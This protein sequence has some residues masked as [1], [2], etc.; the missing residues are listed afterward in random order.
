MPDSLVVPELE[1]ALSAAGEGSAW[2]R[3]ED[4][5]LRAYYP[6]MAAMR[7][8]PALADYLQ[9]HFGKPRSLESLYRHAYRL[10]LRRQEEEN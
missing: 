8:L 7:R 9:R 5:V 4:A 6:R 3:E 1:A 10:G 2:T